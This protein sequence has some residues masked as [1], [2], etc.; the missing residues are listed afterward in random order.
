MSE[1]QSKTIGNLF[2]DASFSPIRKVSFNVENARVEQSTDF[3]KLIIDI[4][5][6]GSI[7]P[8]KAVTSCSCY[9]HGS[10]ILFC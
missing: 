8:E 1:V 6:N 5:T 10:I 4:E 7:E 3:D 2:I 9:T